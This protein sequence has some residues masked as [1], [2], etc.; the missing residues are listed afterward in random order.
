VKKAFEEVPGLQ[1]GLTAPDGNIYALPGLDGCDHCMYPAKLWLNKQ[2]LDNLHLSMPTTTEEFAKVLEAFKN[3][4]PNGNGKPDEI[5]LSG[6][7]QTGSQWSN[8]VTFLMNAFIYDN[9]T[10]YMQMKDGK[11]DLVADEQG[12]KDGLAYIHDLYSKGLIDPAAF[13]QNLG[14]IQQEANSPDGVNLGAFSDLWNGDVVTIYG[15]SDGRWT[16]YF[17]V[18]PLKGPNGKQ[19]A[20]YTEDSVP[21]GKFAITNKADKDQQIAAIKIAD[22][23]YSREG[24]L[25]AFQGVDGWID[26][27]ADQKGIDGKPAVWD[28]APGGMDWEAP[29]SSI[30]EN[31][32]YYMSK[33]LYLGQAVSQ[34]INVQDGNETRLYQ[35]NEQYVGHEPPKEERLPDVFIDPSQAQTVAELQT[36]INK[37][38]EQNEVQFVIGKK[39]LNKDWDAYVKGLQDL[40]SDKYLGIY[41][42]AFDKDK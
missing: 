21:G 17:G 38:I 9:P 11:V 41:Q 34:D 30:W 14:G 32:F 23:M 20:T 10:N 39:D 8:P 42:D 18:A 2:W 27:T 29:S 31:G 28:T 26:A 7:V 1:D 40:G 6:Y 4:D 37:Y 16:H 15:D 22:Y 35:A 3:D 25:D 13:T 33:E 36:T 19:Y 24:A 12:W 5:P